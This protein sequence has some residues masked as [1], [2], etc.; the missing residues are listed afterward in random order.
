MA[1]RWGELVREFTGG[2]PEIERILKNRYEQDPTVGRPDGDPRML[3]YMA[4]L[5]K[6]RKA[7]QTA[8]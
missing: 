7:G 8:E 2:N 3:E 4:Y 1:R 6:A 5:Q